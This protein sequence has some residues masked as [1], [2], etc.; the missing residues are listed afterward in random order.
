M[1]GKVAQLLLFENEL[2]EPSRATEKRQERLFIKNTGL[3]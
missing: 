1:P 2:D 3:C